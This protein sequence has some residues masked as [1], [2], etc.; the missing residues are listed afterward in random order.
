MWIHLHQNLIQDETVCNNIRSRKDS[1]LI[2]SY[3]MYIHLYLDP[4]V[5]GVTSDRIAF[6]VVSPL[7]DSL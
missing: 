3:Q 2:K 4:V 5:D 7:S 6:H 1:P